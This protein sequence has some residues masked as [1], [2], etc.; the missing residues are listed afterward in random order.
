[1]WPVGQADSQHLLCTCDTPGIMPGD[2][3]PT[4]NRELWSLP[5]PS[6]QET[7]KTRMQGDRMHTMRSASV[8]HAGGCRGTEEGLT[9]SEILLAQRRA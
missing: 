5:P 8:G 3:D 1:M 2:W 4:E 7:S 9:A 6:S